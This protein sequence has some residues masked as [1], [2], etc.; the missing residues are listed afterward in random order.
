MFSR[1]FISIILYITLV[2][3][4]FVIKPSMMF[5]IDG[6]L[7]HYDYNNTCE[8]SLLTIE[9]ALPFLAIIS[10]FIIIILEMIIDI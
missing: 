10:Y 5:D 4:I 6:N 7:K 9:I 3:L 1:L 8:T 2:I